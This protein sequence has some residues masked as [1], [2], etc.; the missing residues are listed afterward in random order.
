MR[1]IHAKRS[2]PARMPLAY[3]SDADRASRTT[4]SARIKKA[5][6]RGYR[7]AA[8]LVMK[9]SGSSELGRATAP[10][11]YQSQAAG[12]HGAQ[13]QRGRFRYRNLLIGSLSNQLAIE[14]Q[15]QIKNPFET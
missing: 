9:S 8:P 13:H 1:G 11:N 12:S 2:C 6:S 5:A 3:Q 14:A 10:A 15:L 7:E 4:G